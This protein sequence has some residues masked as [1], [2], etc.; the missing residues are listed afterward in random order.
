MG[1]AVGPATIAASTAV[2]DRVSRS[3]LHS[4]S[5][6]GSSDR[7]AIRSSMSATRWPVNSAVRPLILIRARSWVYHTVAWPA[8][9]NTRTYGSNSRSAHKVTAAVI[10]APPAGSIRALIVSSLSIG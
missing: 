9:P 8:V 1:L 5:P 2:D 7:F 4:T 3:G 6:A 10:G